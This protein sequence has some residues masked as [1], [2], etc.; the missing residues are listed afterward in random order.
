MRTFIKNAHIVSPGIEIAQGFVVIEDD[1]IVSVGSGDAS[2]P[3]GADVIDVPVLASLKLPQIAVGILNSNKVIFSVEFVHN[4]SRWIQVCFAVGVVC[5][6]KHD[7]WC[8]AHEDDD[9]DA[10]DRCELLHG[11]VFLS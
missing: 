8:I 4:S 6:S 3:A 10:G 9:D 11:G 1:K 5:A 2:V 7:D